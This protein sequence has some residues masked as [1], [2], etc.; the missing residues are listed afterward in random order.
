[1]YGKRMTTDGER[2]PEAPPGARVDDARRDIGR[3]ILA[4]A[5]GA[6]ALARHSGYVDTEVQRLYTAAAPPGA[7]ALVAIGGYGRR[8]LCPFSD[9]DLLVLFGGS[10]E[11]AEERFLR[12]L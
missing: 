11:E 8:H 9:I 1:M 2:R 6:S 5:S 10:V 7:V 3:D 12:R 4:G